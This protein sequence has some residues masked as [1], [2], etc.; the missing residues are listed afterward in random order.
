[1]DEGRQ[2][3]EWRSI[4]RKFIVNDLIGSI[5]VCSLTTCTADLVTE[6]GLRVASKLRTLDGI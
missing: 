6:L 4:E 5:R 3:K 2:V 1:M